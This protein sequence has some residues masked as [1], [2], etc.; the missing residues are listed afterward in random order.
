[1]IGPALFHLPGGYVDRAGTV[2]QE[3]ELGSLSGREEELLASY[4]SW[5]RASLVTALLSRC[6]RRLGT[7]RP[8][9]EE[10]ARDLLVADRQYLLLKLREV[11]FGDRVQA[12]MICPQPACRAKTDID[13]S[14]RDVPVQASSDKGPLH[15]VQLSSE[16][17]FV[18]S[19]GKVHREAVFRLPN[20]RDQEAVILIL[21][22]DEIRAAAMLLERCLQ[23]L[24]SLANVNA[25]QLSPLARMELEEHMA[26]LAPRVELTMEGVCPE[27]RQ[28][29]AVPFDLEQF[30]FEELKTSRDLLYREVHYL[31]YHY[32]WSEQEI[33]TMPKEKRRHYM[34]VLAKEIERLHDA[35]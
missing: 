6:I 10:V 28:T 21:M 27:C 22:H 33:M 4:D 29:F 9:S 11:T 24:G 5:Q 30:I 7:I 14:T 26:A 16:A 31:A 2:H 8:V 1:V 3:V 20:G 32:H 17:A 12:T 35:F 34:E 25:E 15:E 18:D 23:R 19:E 13:F